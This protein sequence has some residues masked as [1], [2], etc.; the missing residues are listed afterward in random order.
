MRGLVA[1]WLG[2]FISYQRRRRHVREAFNIGAPDKRL[3]EM[4]T[5]WTI[6]VPI[7]V[8]VI[9]FGVIAGALWGGVLSDYKEARGLYDEYSVASDVVCGRYLNRIKNLNYFRY[10]LMTGLVT[11][12]LTFVLQ[13]AVGLALPC[14][15]YTLLAQVGLSVLA[16][17]VACLTSFKLHDCWKCRNVCGR[18]ECAPGLAVGDQRGGD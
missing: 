17:V 8:C 4:S 5:V 16:G 14:A 7:A 10:A 2:L 6:W 3:F 9:W 13:F 12:L 15:S 11:A 1:G 18:N